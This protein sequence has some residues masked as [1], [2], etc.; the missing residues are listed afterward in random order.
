MPSTY[1]L[2]TVN[3]APERAKPLFE[4]VQNELKDKYDIVPVGNAA[5]ELQSCTIITLDD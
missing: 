2:V 4:K 3:S 5:S 1:K